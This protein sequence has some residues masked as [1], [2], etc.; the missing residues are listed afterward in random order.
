M[1]GTGKTTGAKN[2]GY[3]LEF[4][5]PYNK[6]CQELRKENYNSV[7]LNKLLNINIIGE[8]NKK[9]KQHDI[10]QY[11]AICFVEIP[12][13]GPHYLSKI[14]NFMTKTDRKIFATGDVDQLK[15]IGLEL[16]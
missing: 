16:M 5:T 2:S 10:S 3:K 11:E 4:V 7:T 15:P 13:Y 1:P 8:Y 9:A 6:L 12:M 14:Y